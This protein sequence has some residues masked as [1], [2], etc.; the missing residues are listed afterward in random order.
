MNWRNPQ[1][2]S[3]PVL[4]SLLLHGLVVVALLWHWPEP[5]RIP[6]P[7]PQHVIAQVIQE[8]NA[9]EKQ[10][11]LEAEKRKRQQELAARRAA[12]QKKKAAEQKKREQEAARKLAEQKKREQA[13]ALKEKAAAEQRAKEKAAQEQAQEKADRQRAEQQRQQEQALAEQLAREQAAQQQKAEQEAKR[14]A[15]RAAVLEADFIEQIRAKVS[16]VWRYPPSVR[17][18]QE[19]SVRIQLV[20]TG[21]VIQV[22]VVRSSGHAALDRSVE[23][24]VMRASPLPV[25]DDIRLFE[26]KF[27]NLT[28]NFR[29]ENATW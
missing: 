29:P 21:E 9:A 2:Y 15:E 24:A 11:K 5:Q 20:P 12:E 13:L 19:V 14:Q 27:R 17:P 18:D 3:L 26:Q 10:R 1:H 8:E 23:Q 25:P 22:Q 4:V 16:S 28:I 7:V 6:E